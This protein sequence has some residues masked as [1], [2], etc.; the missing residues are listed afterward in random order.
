VAVVNSIS[1]VVTTGLPQAINSN[2]ISAFEI[3]ILTPFCVPFAT[4]I[5]S[6]T[7]RVFICEEPKHVSP[8]GADDVLNRRNWTLELVSATPP[9]SERVTEPIIEKVENPQPRP[10]IV[11]TGSTTTTWSVDIR[12]DRPIV[13]T[14]VYRII[15]GPLVS[16]ALGTLT[17]PPDPYDRAEF[18]G[19][20]SIRP[21]PPQR[22][23]QQRPG[24]D[25][26]YDTFEGV[27]RL[28]P[29][30]DLQTHEGVSAAKKRILRRI[31]S[32]DGFFHL[33]GYGVGLEVKKL[34]N[35]TRISELSL[36]LKEK[37][38]EEEEVDAVSAQITNEIGLLIIQ[39]RVRLRTGGTFELTVRRDS[40]SESV[41]VV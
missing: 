38:L 1:G 18:P 30:K 24:I 26:F 39:L 29:K 20:F 3:E 21:L 12:V 35:P 33:P 40:D 9:T 37:I 28:D 6:N 25:F 15:M 7:I 17:T 34:F 8:L 23:L 2:P 5:N 41:I 19:I 36:K 11:I 13:S 31:M 16:N 27:F 4:P 14:A 10:E 22:P 32:G